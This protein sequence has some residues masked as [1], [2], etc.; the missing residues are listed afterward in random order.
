MSLWLP[1]LYRAVLADSGVLKDDDKATRTLGIG[2]NMVRSIQFWGE[3]MGV[4]RPKQGGGHEPGP[5]G[6]LL[7]GEN[8]CIDFS[9]YRVT[10]VVALVVVHTWQLGCMESCFWR[11]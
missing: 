5:L 10:L 3:S 11:W 2:R 4:V 6:S 8:G 1:K 9:K 7:L